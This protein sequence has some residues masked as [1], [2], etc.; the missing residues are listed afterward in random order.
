MARNALILTP[1]RKSTPEQRFVAAIIAQAFSDMSGAATDKVSQSTSNSNNAQ[2]AMI[3]LTERHGAFAKWR[4]ELCD[5]LGFD[6]DV[7]AERVRSILDSDLPWPRQLGAQGVAIKH[8]EQKPTALVPC[9][10]T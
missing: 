6:G 3:F 9:G 4:N 8:A 2:R 5:Y 10:S 7:L 1:G